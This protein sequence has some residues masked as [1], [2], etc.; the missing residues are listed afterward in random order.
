MADEHH[1]EQKEGGHG[2]GAGGHGHGPPHGGGHE[3][4]H[5]GA[6]EWLISFADN[7]T[8][9]MGFFVIMLAFSMKPSESAARPGSGGGEGGAEISAE[10]LDWAIGV[11]AAFNN[12]VQIDSTDP[13]DAALVQR[14]LARAG[15]GPA[16]EDNPRGRYDQTQT[17]RPSDYYGSGGL[18]GFPGGGTGLDE[19]AQTAITAIAEHL[20][21]FR[22]V[23]ELRGHS[24]AAEAHGADDGGLALAHARAMAVA[25]ALADAGVDWARLRVVA[26]GSAEPLAAPAYDT[27]A[28]GANQRVEVIATDRAAP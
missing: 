2:R 5:E 7:V 21:G 20:R 26:C 15:G 18:V 19:E 3:E 27:A 13:R 24:S 9:M 22:N 17:I 23:I 12:P 6:P 16:E 1:D 8:L 11:R 25:Q 14:L 28:H 4:G 10:L